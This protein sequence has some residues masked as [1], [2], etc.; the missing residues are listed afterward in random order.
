MLHLI[1][2]IVI[3]ILTS[4]LALA[5]AILPFQIW[6]HF[7]VWVS[8]QKVE[9]SIPP[10]ITDADELGN[11]Q[12]TTMSDAEFNDYWK[13]VR[14]LFSGELHGY[15]SMGCYYTFTDE[16]KKEYRVGI[17]KDTGEIVKNG[18]TTHYV[19]KN[20]LPDLATEQDLKNEKAPNLF[21]QV[22]NCLAAYYAGIIFI[23][24]ELAD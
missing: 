18:K 15:G 10:E 17:E 21:E 9:K 14:P 24:F 19:K 6:W 1:K 5:A 23:A 12:R 2:T 8:A 16:N 20:A 22:F 3:F 4:L 7:P 13:E 11:C